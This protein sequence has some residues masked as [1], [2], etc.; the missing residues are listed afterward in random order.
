MVFRMPSQ[1]RRRKRRRRRSPRKARKARRE[2]GPTP[3]PVQAAAQVPAV[4]VPAA[5]VAVREP[6]GCPPP[7]LLQSTTKRNLKLWL[8]SLLHE[9]KY[10]TCLCGVWRGGLMFLPSV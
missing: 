10:G 8:L 3:V 2:K 4:Q 6:I 5:G 9:S 7:S 1:R